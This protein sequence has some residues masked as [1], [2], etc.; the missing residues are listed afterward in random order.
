MNLKATETADMD[1]REKLNVLSITVR[2]RRNHDNDMRNGQGG[3][4]HVLGNIFN[5]KHSSST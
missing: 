1:R 4:S 2:K 5:C 3:A